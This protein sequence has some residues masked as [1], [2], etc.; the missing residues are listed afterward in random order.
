MRLVMDRFDIVCR[1][2]VGLHQHI[3]I[4]TILVDVISG[5]VWALV[6]DL[7]K[8]SRLILICILCFGFISI[9]IAI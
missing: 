7:I 2:C 3:Q 9:M 1:L 6:G 5:V 4:L 8:I